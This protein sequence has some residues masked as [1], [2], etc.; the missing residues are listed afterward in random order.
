MQNDDSV[1]RKNKPL[2]VSQRPDWAKS[3]PE[4][5]W[6]S[7]VHAPQCRV[8]NANHNGRSLRAEIEALV[9]ERKTYVEVCD[10]VF[11]RYGL[12]L[13][14]HNVSRHMAR[15]APGYTKMLAKLLENDLGEVL[16]G[17]HGMFVDAPKFLLA[18][19]QMSLHNGLLHPEQVTIADGIRAAG[20]L[21]LITKGSE[22]Q[23]PDNAVT[24]DDINTLIDCMQEVLTPEQK[25]EVERRFFK[26]RDDRKSE[27]SPPA[28]GQAPAWVDEE[29]E[30][31][32]DDEYIAH[33]DLT[34]LPVEDPAGEDEE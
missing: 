7:Y 11:E 17:A 12:R 20:K 16:R 27:S 18:V 30:V 15:H 5:E 23:E 9:L 3:M 4:E 32:V 14:P 1:T 28:Q 21:A 13:A 10:I 6:E 24:Q 22:N 8:C 26:L 34:A 29:N 31:F 33:D 19:L 2:P 25:V